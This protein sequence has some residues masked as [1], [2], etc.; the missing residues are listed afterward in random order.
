MESS[1]F[2]ILAPE[3]QREGCASFSGAL[4]REFLSAF[5]AP[6][7][8]NALA[9]RRML[10]RAETVCPLPFF[11]FWVIGK[12]HAYDGTRLEGVLQVV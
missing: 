1:S 11:L 5:C 9:S 3:N 2:G 12:R 10:P 4:Y 8:K 7:G 6:A